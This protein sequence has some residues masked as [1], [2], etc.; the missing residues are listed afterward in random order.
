MILRYCFPPG[1]SNYCYEH[2]KIFIKRKVFRLLGFKKVIY[3]NLFV[4]Y[5]CIDF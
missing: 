1:I 4:F 5:D 2:D 3:S